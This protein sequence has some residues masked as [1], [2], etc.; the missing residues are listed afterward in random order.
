MNKTNSRRRILVDFGFNETLILKSERNL[1][2]AEKDDKIYRVAIHEN[3]H[4]KYKHLFEDDRDFDS[5]ANYYHALDANLRY[6]LNLKKLNQI[7]TNVP[8][9]IDSYY[10]ENEEVHVLVMSKAEGTV[11]SKVE[12]NFSTLDFFAC[13]V[14]HLSNLEKDHGIYFVDLHEENIIFGNSPSDFC[15]IDFET[16]IDVKLAKNNNRRF[17]PLYGRLCLTWPI[18]VGKIAEEDNIKSWDDF[19]DLVMKI[20][21]TLYKCFWGELGIADIPGVN[22]FED[23][24]MALEYLKT[25]DFDRAVKLGNLDRYPEEITFILEDG[26]SK[27]KLNRDLG[28]IKPRGMSYGFILK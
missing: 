9:F 5:H 27:Y 7:T 21:E 11:L 17:M 1:C 25:G 26:V 16:R 22:T 12:I 13:A 28:I 10:L 2:I 4:K 24:Y 8:R 14:K 15:L 19:F 6:V 3:H 18:L 20:D 23:P